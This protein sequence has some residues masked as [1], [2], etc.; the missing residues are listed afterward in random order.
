PVFRGHPMRGMDAT[1]RRASARLFM[2][3]LAA[4]LI[5]VPP[6][7]GQPASSND[8][9]DPYQTAYAIPRMALPG[10]LAEVTLPTPLSP[11]EVAVARRVFAD[12]AAG[13]MTEAARV[14]ATLTT[15][16]LAGP[17]LA[18]RL[19]GRFHHAE[20]AE[21][22]AWLA[23]YGTQA[24]TPAIRAL[25]AKRLPPRAAMPPH[26][27]PAT[28]PAVVVSDADSDDIGTP[29]VSAGEALRA[30]VA[31]DTGLAAWRKGRIAR[32]LDCF[33]QAARADGAP[34]SLRAEGA[35]W[36]ARAALRRHDVSGYYGW[37]RRAAAERRTFHGLI[38]RRVLGWGTGL[39]LGHEILSQADVDALAA[40]PRARR[41]FALLQVGQKAG[42]EAEF[43]A[44]WP[45]IVDN[46]PLC[47]ALLLAT[48]EAHLT[49]LAAQLAELVREADGVPHDALQFPV[50]PLHP[51]G[52]FVVDQALVYGL[53]RTESNFDPAAVSPAGARGL[54][55]IM[56][57]T[58]R[59]VSGNPRLKMVSLHDPA[60]NL[61]LGQQLVLKLAELPSVHGDL[62]R[63]LGSYNA[64]AAGFAD[65]IGTRIDEADPMLFIDTIPI[66]ETRRFV[67][68][69]FASSWIYAA[70]LGLTAPGLDDLANGRVPGLAPA[71]STDR[72][73][74][75][76]DLREVRLARSER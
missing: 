40:I 22:E 71:N 17:V 31:V 23:H 46:A 32:A 13:R 56:P 62:I 64:G 8:A 33:G 6:A 20:P 35:Y 16:L 5:L 76:H 9:S 34:A 11:A 24:D 47:R 57:I 38:A 29:G 72:P 45:E 30:R 39:V 43:R 52:G 15:D 69:V 12:Q 60:L 21:L 25:L 66:V 41:A 10:S 75:V 26:R 55:Q 4:F 18:D 48:A 36:A 61:G 37:L 14:N 58:A 27:E 28:L 65:A 63:L 67:Q 7:I 54:M 70:R 44:L 1:P 59:A 51:A 3:V 49:D 42:A 74:V 68:R 50:P 2:A 19:L 53:T 73:D